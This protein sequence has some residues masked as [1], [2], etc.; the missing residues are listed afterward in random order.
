MKPTTLTEEELREIEGRPEWDNPVGKFVTLRATERDA[1][2]AMARE[3]DELRRENERLTARVGGVITEA[4]VLIQQLTRLAEAARNVA[5]SLVVRDES[6]DAALGCGS[7]MEWTATIRALAQREE[8][9]L[10]EES[11]Q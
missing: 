8:R 5:E 4:G 10:P 11:G 6:L 3:R 7:V 1:L 9:P 2:C